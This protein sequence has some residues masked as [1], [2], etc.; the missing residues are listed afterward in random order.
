MATTGRQSKF[1][2]NL[3]FL[4][5]SILISNNHRL[6]F[7]AD[8]DPSKYQLAKGSS[9]YLLTDSSFSSQN[10]AKVRFEV[11]NQYTD[12]SSFSGVDIRLYKIPD[13]IN[14]L[15]AQKNLHRPQV[16]DR[17]RGEG[18][19]N[20]LSYLW[21]SWYKKS[22]LAWQRIISYVARKPIVEHLP[23]VKQVPPHL[24]KTKFANNPQFAP[25]E[26]LPIVDT[27][28]Y[29]LWAAK[30]IKPPHDVALSGSSSNFLEEKKGNIYVS[31]GV[32]KPGL[33]L[34][35][36]M[37]GSFRATTFVFVSDSLA[38]TKLSSKQQLVWVVDKQS[39]TPIASTKIL[40]TDGIGVIGQGTT[41]REG[42]YI[43]TGK[44]FERSYVLGED[45]SGGVFVSENFY[46]DSEL[47]GN[48]IYMF[49]DRP[50]YRPGD[51]VQI[52]LMGQEFV[53]SSQVKPLTGSQAEIKVFDSQGMQM[54]KK[55]I[56]LSSESRGGDLSFQ[57]P[58]E[59]TQGGYSI[60]ALYN[61]GRYLASF[62]VADYIKPHFDI[63][64]DIQTSGLTLGTSIEGKLQLNY[65]NGK[66]VK[67]AAIDL[68]VK[69]QKLS[70]VEGEIEYL[71]RF[72]VELETISLTSDDAGRV[73]FSIP[74]AKS[75]SRYI[76]TALAVDQTSF[77]VKATKE[78]VIDA[79]ENPRLISTENNFSA[80]EESVKFELKA[81]SGIDNNLSADSYMW[82]AIRIEDQTELNGALAK[83]NFSITF[84]KSG[85]YSIVVKNKQGMTVATKSHWVQGPD[86]AKIPGSISIVLDKDEY[87]PRQNAK[88]VVTFSEDIQDAL[89]TFERDQVQNA[90]LLSKGGD[91]IRFIKVSGREYTAEI[92]IR[93]EF[94]PN[95]T[96]SIAYVRNGRYFFEN[97]GIKV[98]TPKV[99]IDFA[100]SK[101]QFK[102]GE[103][104]DVKV[105]T[106]F[107]GRPIESHLAISVVDEMIYTLQPEIAPH[108]ADF[109]FHP[110]RNQVRTSSSLVFHS[111]NPAV[112]A[113]GAID[114][115]PE[116]RYP[117]RGLK[118]PAERQRR[119]DI[120][121]AFW[122]PDLKTGPDGKG[123]FSFVMPDSIT[124]WR[125]TGRAV[126]STGFVGQSVSF[127]NSEKS[128]YVTW[129]GPSIYR[130]GDSAQVNLVLFNQN[131]ESV[132]VNLEAKGFGTDRI[133]E[134]KLNPGV[135]YKGFQFNAQ[136]VGQDEVSLTLKQGEVQ[137][138]PKSWL[139]RQSLNLSEF[140][141]IPMDASH[142]QVSVSKGLAESVL[143][144]IDDLADYPYGCVEQ[145]SSRLLPLSMGF[146][147]IQKMNESQELEGILRTRLTNERIRLVD[148]AGKD[149]K[150]SWWGNENNLSAFMTAYAYYADWIAT[151]ALEIDLSKKHWE[152]VAST[153]KDLGKNESLLNKALIIWMLGEM[154]APTKTLITGLF[155]SELNESSMSNLSSLDL[156][157]Q[158]HAVALLMD[159]VA[160][161][162]GASMP[163]NWASAV[164]EAKSKVIENQQPFLNSLLILHK[165]VTS[166]LTEK[167]SSLIAD[168]LSRLS[169]ESS[170][171]E[172]ALSL[173]FLNS[174]IA[175]Q[176][177]VSPSTLEL[178]FG[179]DWLKAKSTLGRVVWDFKGKVLSKVAPISNLPIDTVA[180][181]NFDSYSDESSSLPLKISR[182]FAKLDIE[183]D[184]GYTFNASAVSVGLSELSNDDL[185]LDTIE[186]VADGPQMYQ[187]G[188][189]EVAL[190]PGADVDQTTWGLKVKDASGKDVTLGSP[191]FQNGRNSYSV[192]V[193]KF[194]GSMRIHHLIRFSQSGEFSVPPVRYFKMYAP[195]QKAF[196]GGKSSDFQKFIVK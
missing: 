89:V 52:R 133:I 153:Y 121:T 137:I 72:P 152:V 110:R 185:Y 101:A 83:E 172:R 167:E 19:T 95:M 62:R 73:S 96:L 18:L 39:G 6:A 148:L 40:M 60:E 56:K 29:P 14:F 67:G 129:T 61:S 63:D 32:L 50:V 136:T 88:A 139:T 43:A 151:K 35:E 188:L 53:T 27:F 114:A 144:V 1:Y 85:S 78:I 165:K 128:H 11:S 143:R 112:S 122:N 145:T 142:L 126:A 119:D 192:G 194:K 82:H 149:A 3:S 74:G 116:N 141:K 59:G 161:K 37:I 2:W 12:L 164:L 57:I 70:I 125:L 28:R 10:V 21:D 154:G 187:F 68:Q 135:N 171:L 175:S 54:I 34:V 22:R 127:V 191:S 157:G 196:E 159:I 155:N 79:I 190:P 195:A 91:W 58:K 105:L 120:D 108:I 163:A 124:K 99:K 170:T 179:S 131:N 156:E 118:L 33:Y 132:K 162:A 103:K 44:D 80:P 41:N 182:S 47:Y 113:L 168:L 158:R 177:K 181:V 49:T 173:S 66:A 76:L 24:Y 92:P 16:S 134:V 17:Y 77:R 65:P 15:K 140:D 13:P 146:S 183:K 48:K 42:I 186:I 4:I 87:E 93:D 51:F 26:G 176:M 23:D 178:N 123:E 86:L 180:K 160:K 30:S 46:Y 97:K 90:G 106:T 150:F 109:F 75:P 9:F 117:E 102:P 115:P 130:L 38:I 71:D 84:T 64:F 107:K 104:V 111:Y 55:T 31:L 69:S 45:S 7:A 20:A 138:V 193:D 25:I 166:T 189:L 100:M 36:G 174:V 94:S 184:E 169:P 98:T 81:R 147:F 5:F 8:I